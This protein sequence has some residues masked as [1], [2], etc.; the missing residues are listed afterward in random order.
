MQSKD[1]LCAISPILEFFDGNTLSNAG[2]RKPDSLDEAHTEM[3]ESSVGILCTGTVTVVSRESLSELAK[4]H[5]LHKTMQ[6]SVIH[7][8]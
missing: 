7:A 5:D 8:R 3:D 1:C 6:A 2:V 4:G